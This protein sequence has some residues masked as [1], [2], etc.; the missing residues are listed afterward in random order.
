MKF[1]ACQLPVTPVVRSW[2][3]SSKVAAGAIKG[4]FRRDECSVDRI[5]VPHITAIDHSGMKTRDYYRLVYWGKGLPNPG[6]NLHHR[7]R[8]IQHLS[9]YKR[10]YTVVYGFGQPA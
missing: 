10:K 7:A 9:V 3:T 4:I 6:S 8:T 5:Q 2:N 1:F